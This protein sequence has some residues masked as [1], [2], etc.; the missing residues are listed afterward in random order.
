LTN[1]LKNF[2]KFNYYL[3]LRSFELSLISILKRS[4]ISIHLSVIFYFLLNGLIYI[5]GKPVFHKF[6]QLYV[7]DRLQFILSYAYII[8]YKFFFDVFEKHKYTFLLNILL[9]TNMNYLSSYHVTSQILLKYNKFFNKFI[10]LTVD[11]PN[12]LEVDYITNLISVVYEPFIF[13]EFDPILLYRIP[14]FSL[15]IYN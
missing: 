5:N 1:Y 9:K 10:N 2:K 14:F 13:F 4:L 7:G 11:V 3:S 12:F 6:S 15:K 8:H